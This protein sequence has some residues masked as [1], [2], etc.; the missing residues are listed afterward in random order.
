MGEPIEST[1]QSSGVTPFRTFTSLRLQLAIAAAAMCAL[2]VFISNYWL[3][4]S[5]DWHQRDRSQESVNILA[6]QLVVAAAQPLADSDDAFLAKIGREILKEN[7]DVIGVSFRTVGG[8]TTTEHRDS[9]GIPSPGVVVSATRQSLLRTRLVGTVGVS[10]R[11]GSASSASGTPLEN[12]LLYPFLAVGILFAAFFLLLEKLV[13]APVYSAIEAATRLGSGKTVDLDAL[14][15]SSQMNSIANA[16][17]RIQDEIEIRKSRESDLYEA[18]KRLT[19]VLQS[20]GEAI[21]SVNQSGVVIMSN[22]EAEYTWGYDAGELL[23][24]PLERLMPAR[25]RDAHRAGFERFLRDRAPRVLGKRVELVGLHKSGHE[26][27]LELLIAETSADPEFVFTAAIRDI[28]KRK[29]EQEALEIAREQSESA[30]RTKSVFLATISHE[31]RTPLN[32]I[33]GALGEISTNTRDVRDVELLQAAKHSGT[34][35]SALI[36]DVLDLSKIEAGKLEVR[37]EDVSIPEVVSEIASTLDAAAEGKG[38]SLVTVVHASAWGSGLSDKQ[39]LSQILVNLIGNAIKFTHAGWVRLDVTRD[40]LSSG[41]C[42]LCI[43][44][45]DTGPGIAVH[46]RERIFEEFQQGTMLAPS[47]AGLGLSISKHLANALGGDVSYSPLCNRSGS[48]FELCVRLDAWT[49]SKLQPHVS[50]TQPIEIV[51]VGFDGPTKTA[52]SEQ[53]LVW[54]VSCKQSIQDSSRDTTF[55]LGP[56]LTAT[57]AELV[58]DRIKDRGGRC[59]AFL[60]SK[61]FAPKSWDVVADLVTVPGPPV[62]VRLYQEVSRRIGDSPGGLDDGLQSEQSSSPLRGKRVLLAEDSLGNQLVLAKMM[63]RMQVDIELAKD[64]QAA[65][66][67]ASSKRFDL[68][69]LD[70]LMPILD[71]ISVA[72]SIRGRPGPNQATPVM[73]LTASATADI[74]DECEAAGMSSFVTKPIDLAGLRDAMLRVLSIDETARIGVLLDESILQRL[75]EDVSEAAMPS[76]IAKIVQEVS[77][78]LVDLQV[79]HGEHNFDEIKRL[80]HALKSSV[81]AFGLTALANAC[82]RLEVSLSESNEAVGELIAEV[83]KRGEASIAVLLSRQ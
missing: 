62:P 25:L 83:G 56:N 47:G 32:V 36:G 21:L 63:E 80:A 41:A 9:S 14:R 72:K 15:S 26:F 64:G 16:F 5:S 43:S 39:R 53:L 44:V 57:D 1:D 59:L 35:L 22:K 45:T 33:I 79:R 11:T 73:A 29:E 48:K 37:R 76:L 71:G 50:E 42:Q 77:E 30:N 7:A 23:G 46:D 40:E 19:E 6:E 55:L 38:L 52:L 74:R 12:V 58:A 51:T 70:I 4:V 10:V 8:Q 34:L 68:I 28:S 82:E 20:V 78:T 69:I 60:R 18:R 54:G 13:I 66:D 49:P 81:R 17:R 2:V 65:L 75:A 61:S 67:S 31:I 27:P 24:M 3:G